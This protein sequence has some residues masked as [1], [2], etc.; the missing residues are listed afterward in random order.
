[1]IRKFIKAFEAD[2]ENIWIGIVI[3]LVLVI[4]GLTWVTRFTIA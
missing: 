3:T 4:L 1:M 2:P